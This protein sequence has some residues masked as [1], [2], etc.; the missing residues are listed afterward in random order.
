MY[1]TTVFLN[2][3]V[4][5]NEWKINAYHLLIMWLSLQNAHTLYYTKYRWEAAH[6][7][8]CKK[9]SLK[10]QTVIS[11]VRSCPVSWTH[12]YCRSKRNYQSLCIRL[13]PGPER[14]THSTK[15]FTPPTKKKKIILHCP[16]VT[17]NKTVGN[18]SLDCTC[19]LLPCIFIKKPDAA[20]GA[21]PFHNVREDY[22]GKHMW[23][24]SSH[25]LK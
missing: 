12:L 20:A 8:C 16:I 25:Q 23:P 21:L 14:W 19:F 13:I 11:C 10:L 18:V 9:Y 22:K 4:N 17:L 3:F 2:S 15:P 6:I 5:D 7:K 24:T 1:C